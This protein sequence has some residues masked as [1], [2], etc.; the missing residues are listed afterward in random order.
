M[1]E[2]QEVEVNGHQETNGTATTPETNEEMKFP[3]I[4]KAKLAEIH[5]TEFMTKC[6][7][8]VAFAEGFKNYVIKVVHGSAIGDGFVGLIFKV[9]IKEENSEKELNLILKTPPESEARRNQFGSMDLFRREIYVYN[10]VIPEFVKFQ[11]ERKISASQGFCEFPKVY[12]AEYSD[13][14][15]DALIIM[16]DLRERGFVLWDKFKPTPYENAKL[17]MKALG[18]FHAIS[19][20]MKKLKPE[21]F[22]KFKEMQCFFAEKFSTPEMVPMFQNSTQQALTVLDEGNEKQRKRVW[23]LAENFIELIK[24][25]TDGKLDDAFGVVGHGD[26][27]SNNFMYQY[28]VSMRIASE[29]SSGINS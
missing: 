19:F 6:L 3:E 23:H 26:C 28:K 12:Y 1:E 14:L 7:D 24:S 2:H 29:F 18:K 22:N 9:T 8:K 5:V 16:E 11:Q 20:A 17:I 21:V 15:D 13:E 10:E 4:P 27:W 25:T